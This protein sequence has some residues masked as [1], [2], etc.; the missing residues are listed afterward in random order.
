MR[1]LEY[2]GEYEERSVAE[3][4]DILDLSRSVSDFTKTK[5][6]WLAND[7]FGAQPEE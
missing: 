5:P 3:R 2:T 6:K 1:E 4:V 7:T